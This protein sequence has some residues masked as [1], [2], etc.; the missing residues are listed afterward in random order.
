MLIY[1]KII[2]HVQFSQRILSLDY[3]MLIFCILK[4]WIRLWTRGTF[5]SKSCPFLD[6]FLP[7]LQYFTLYV[8]I[9][10]VLRWGRGLRAPNSHC[11]RPWWEALANLSND[12]NMN[13]KA[14]FE[15]I[16][17]L[18][19]QELFYISQTFW[20]KGWHQYLQD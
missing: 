4:K 12:Q 1:L 15:I 18:K 17:F 10:Q 8:I 9:F 16:I 2:L 13:L 3:F 6:F 20:A 11:V 5:V 19:C 14:F 7:M